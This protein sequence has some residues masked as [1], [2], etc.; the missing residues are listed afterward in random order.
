MQSFDR[1]EEKCNSK[2]GQFPSFFCDMLKHYNTEHMYNY[3][4]E[5]T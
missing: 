3:N 5:L 2:E 1:I 4:R